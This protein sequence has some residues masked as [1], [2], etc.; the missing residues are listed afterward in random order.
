MEKPCLIDEGEYP[1]DR[2]LSRCLGD[3]KEA[4]DAFVAFLDSS[5]PGCTPEWRYYNDGKSWLCKV[6]E[7][8]K[9]ICWLSVYRGRFET[10]F[11]FPDRAESLIADSSIRKT[12]KEQF[13]NAKRFGKTRALTVDVRKTADLSTTKKLF[14]IKDDFK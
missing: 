9:T 7:K 1:D 14:A 10:T 6:V 2:V 3:A 5:Y 8:S 4:W 11:Y 13:L 12:Y